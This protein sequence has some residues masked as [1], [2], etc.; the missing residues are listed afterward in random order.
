LREF[1]N[2]CAGASRS[3]GPICRGNASFPERAPYF[4]KANIFLI[5]QLEFRLFGSILYI[6]LKAGRAMTEQ[7]KQKNAA[8]FVKKRTGK[9]CEKVMCVENPRFEEQVRRGHACFVYGFIPD[10]PMS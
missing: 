1:H 2:A 6:K 10:A 9:G 7:E 4:I 8:D 3:I 5:V